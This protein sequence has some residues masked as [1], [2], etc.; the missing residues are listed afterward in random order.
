M[1]AWFQIVPKADAADKVQA[2]CCVAVGTGIATAVKTVVGMEA[3]V[4]NGS[5]IAVGVGRSVGTDATVAV[6][7]GGVGRTV[8]AT[9][10]LLTAPPT[11][12]VI[13]RRNTATPQTRPITKT[14]KTTPLVRR[15]LLTGQANG[16]CCVLVPAESGKVVPQA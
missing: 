7:C 10:A 1:V 8:A 6:G 16:A 5:A 3:M 2:M 14:I 15:K 11:R 13:S 12:V 9:V 4:G